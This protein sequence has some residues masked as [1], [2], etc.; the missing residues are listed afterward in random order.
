MMLTA[1]K[2]TEPSL[3]QS[4]E[5]AARKLLT[6]TGYRKLKRIDC[7]YRDGEMTLRGKVPSYYHKQLAQECIRNAPHVARI[8]NQLEVVPR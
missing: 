1:A 4:V 5:R 6:A 2:P 3:R 7:L 8:V